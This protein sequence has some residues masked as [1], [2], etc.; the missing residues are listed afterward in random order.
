MLFLFFG[1]GFG[2]SMHSRS[3]CSTPEHADEAYPVEAQHAMTRE[4][5]NR[6]R[7]NLNI[8]FCTQTLVHI[9]VACSARLSSGSPN[10]LQLCASI[11]PASK[12]F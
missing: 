4:L 12:P 2:P 7:Q 10:P 5:A 1:G 8:K 3:A 6:I 9:L 11:L